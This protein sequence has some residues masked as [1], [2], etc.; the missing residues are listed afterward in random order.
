[1][2]EPPLVCSQHRLS[3]LT[4]QTDA[5][6]HPKLKAHFA[7][8]E[9]TMQRLGVRVVLEHQRR[10]AFG[11]RKV[12][13][14]EH[15]INR[16]LVEQS[17]F[18]PG[19]PNRSRALILINIVLVGVDTDPSLDVVGR[20]MSRHKVLVGDTR[21]TIFIDVVKQFTETPIANGS[22]LNPLANPN[23]GDRT[24]DAVSHGAIDP[25]L[26]T[27]IAVRLERGDR[28]HD[29]ANR[30][31]T[32]RQFLTALGVAAIDVEFA[33]LGEPHHEIRAEER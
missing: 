26:P 23:F 32:G 31:A 25:A 29:P 14:A 8:L 12:E 6:L 4:K 24:T 11:L 17:E 10:T 3:N 15:S 20:N 33:L 2:S 22:P 16:Q 30:A 13:R 27:T 18:T 28:F 5:I 1:M 7:V 19:S 21:I 9:P